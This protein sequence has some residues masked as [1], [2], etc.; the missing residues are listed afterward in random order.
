[1]RVP[2][3]IVIMGA[4]AIAAS[5][6]LK[7]H[8]TSLS[9]SEG[10]ASL[11]NAGWVRDDED[12]WN[13]GHETEHGDHYILRFGGSVGGPMV[14]NGAQAPNLPVKEEGGKRSVGLVGSDLGNVHDRIP[15]K[16]RRV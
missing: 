14:M 12:W 7:V 1:M 4:A 5:L 15:R 3:P 11:N 16:A 9:K 13:D 10:P 2:T 8:D 6:P